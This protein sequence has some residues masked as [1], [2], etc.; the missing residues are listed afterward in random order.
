M[1]IDNSYKQPYNQSFCA[2]PIAKYCYLQEKTKDVVVYK[3]EKRDINYLKHISDNIDKFYKRNNIKDESTMQV[4]KEAFEAAVEILKGKKSFEEKAKILLAMFGEEP[5]AIL[6]GNT[7]KVDKNGNFHYSSRKNHSK[8]ETELDWLATWNKKI[9]G[10][11]KVIVT[12]FFNSVLKDGFKQVYVRSE[13]PEKSFAMNFYKKM[14]FDTLSDEAREIQRKNDNRYLI[15]NFDDF[16][17]TIIPMKATTQD[18][19]ESYNKHKKELD[20]FEL[21]NHPSVELP[22]LDF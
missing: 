2:I 13:I 1:K 10:E 16:E 20:R 7:L 8:D 22:E 11:G 21:V 19:L 4:V 15:G 17:D 18:M 12:E 14:G 6:I 3:L 9:F 5:S